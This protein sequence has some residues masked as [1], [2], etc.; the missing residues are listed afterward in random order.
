MVILSVVAQSAGAAEYINCI[1]AEEQDFP[2]ECPGYDTKQSGRQTSVMPE[3]WGMQGTLSMP[4]LPG[5]LLS[6]VATLD[7][8]LSMGQRTKPCN[9]AKNELF[10]IN[11]FYI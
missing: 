3:L 4:S 2:N 10:E 9:Y 6:G 5:Q 8:V 1:T 11:G 7:I